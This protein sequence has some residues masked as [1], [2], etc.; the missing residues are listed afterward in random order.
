MLQDISI[1]DPISKDPGKKYHS[2]HKKQ[3]KKKHDC[4]NKLLNNNNNNKK[5]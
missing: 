4:I 3:N 1:S 2:F 5:W